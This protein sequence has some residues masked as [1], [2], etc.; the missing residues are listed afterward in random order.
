MHKTNW[1][2]KRVARGNSL[3][4]AAFHIRPTYM[5]TVNL[6]AERFNNFFCWYF[7]LCPFQTDYNNGI[8]KLSSEQKVRKTTD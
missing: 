2:R 3:Q 6:L 8:D 5:Y 4:I 1:F 7:S